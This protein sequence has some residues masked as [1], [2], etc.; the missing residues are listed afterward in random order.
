M[1]GAEV[2]RGRGEPAGL[3]RAFCGLGKDG[4]L[5][6]KWRFTEDAGDR[7]ADYSPF[8]PC[9]ASGSHFRHRREWPSRGRRA[10]P[11]HGR[12]EAEE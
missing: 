6:R 10:E 12:E 8:Y 11:F 5:G 1:W 2:D 9:P 3:V 4:P 7:H